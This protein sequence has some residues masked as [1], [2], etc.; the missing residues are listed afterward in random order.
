MHN[1]YLFQSLFMLWF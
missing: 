1:L